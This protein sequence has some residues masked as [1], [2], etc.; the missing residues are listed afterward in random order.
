MLNRRR[1]ERDNIIDL[2]DEMPL[3]GHDSKYH[4]H[5]LLALKKKHAVLQSAA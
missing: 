3:E 5:R 1:D 2:S 4:V